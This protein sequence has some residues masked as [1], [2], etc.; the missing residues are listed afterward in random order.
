MVHSGV[1]EAKVTN[2]EMKLRLVPVPG[3]EYKGCSAYIFPKSWKC[4]GG[5]NP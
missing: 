3:M 2:S 1:T 5:R 4:G